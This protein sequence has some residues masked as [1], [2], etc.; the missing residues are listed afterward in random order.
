MTKISRRR[1]SFDAAAIA[2][3][4]LSSATGALGACGGDQNKGSS[5]ENAANL[6]LTAE[7]AREVDAKL[8]NVTRDFGDRLSDEQR[9]RLRRILVHNEKMLA[10]IRAFHV[11]NG[12]PPASV[13]R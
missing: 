7:Q 4:S 1:F 8:S 13:L 6:G 9:Q 5:P 2:A 10:S 3:T 12:D 11:D